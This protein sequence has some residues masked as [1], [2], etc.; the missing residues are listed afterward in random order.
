MRPTLPPQFSADR[1]TVGS[2]IATPRERGSVPT[3]TL[4]VLT[5]TPFFP[6]FGDDAWGCFIAEPLRLMPRLGIN[7]T[8][9]AVL[10][11]HREFGR[12]PTFADGA[13]A[14]RY[15]AIPGNP[16]LS[17][18]GAFLYAQLRPRVRRLHRERPIDLIHAHVALPCGQA[19]AMLAGDLGI[20][21]V[22]SVHGL[23]VFAT[24]QVRG[25]SGGWCAQASRRVY[26]SA[27]AI[28][29]VSD[30][31]R[32]QVAGG[33]DAMG[34]DCRVV[35]NGADPRL[36]SPIPES[37]NR[38]VI[39]SVGN[40]DPIKGHELVVRAVHVLKSAH[41]SLQYEIIGTGPEMPR[42]RALARDLG[43]ADSVVFLGRQNRRE[44]ARRMQQCS[45]F[46]LP[47]RYEAIGCV[48]LEAMSCGKPAIGCH[49]QGIS[50]II[51][52]GENGWLIHPGN[53]SELVAGLDRLLGD[54][55]LRRRLGEA[56]R[57]IVLERLTI[58]HQ[59]EAWARIYRDHVG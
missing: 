55:A 53:L 4:H 30:K 42:L 13:C 12:A 57:R 35:Y 44:V 40:L 38:E 3:R 33:M 7:S 48:Y 34:L 45:A 11:F 25:L 6:H 47:S 56:G 50:E 54:A 9:L 46:V 19:A 15:L 59:A 22:V 17:S 20:P 8:V 24:N 41:P 2:E 5:L 18:S 21:F 58:A 26:R 23:D 32:Q 37:A 49:E 27:S 28:I 39:L 36:F 16:G 1:E 29:C 43:I 31:V 51:G 14:V 10:P 52:H